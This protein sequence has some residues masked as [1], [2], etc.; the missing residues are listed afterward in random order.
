MC[1]RHDFP[2]IDRDCQRCRLSE[3]RTQLVV[4]SGNESA[5]LM[6]IGEAPGRKEDEGGMPFIGAAGRI[7][8]GLLARAGLSRDEIYICNVVKCRPPQN[9]NPKPDEIAAC[10]PYLELQIARIAPE[11]I[12]ALGSVAA[13]ALTGFSAPMS[14]RH[15]KESRLKLANSEHILFTLYHPAATIYNRL[16]EDEFLAAG[17]ALADALMRTHE[18]D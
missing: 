1:A 14:V 16:L 5:R 4:G 15:G 3:G 18:R 11:I 12:V 8:D 17:D 13:E 9:R 10:R 6:F 7:L 2:E